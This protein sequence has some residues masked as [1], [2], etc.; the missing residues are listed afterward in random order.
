MSQT[1]WTIDGPEDVSVELEG[2]RFSSNDEGAPM[3]CNLVCQA[4]G[5]HVHITNCR[6]GADDAAACNGNDQIE[7]ILKRLHPNPD[8]PKDFVTHN[9]FW[10]RA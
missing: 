9:L 7:H 6:H 2:R 10:R 4:M 1:R 3:M 5:I 8:D